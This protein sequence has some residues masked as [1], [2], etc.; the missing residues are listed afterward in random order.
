MRKLY[1]LLPFLF[2]SSVI[3]SQ[4]NAFEID[5]VKEK[6][7]TPY[8]LYRHQGEEG[9]AAFKKNQPFDYAKELWY[10]SE[11]FYVK[12]NHLSQGEVLNAA[13]IDI[14]RFENY[15]KDTEEAIVVV[16]GYKDVLVLLPNNKLLYKPN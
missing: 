3:L 9:L 12:R 14:S 6:M 2:L 11:S 7:F 4:N 1:I 15:R 5:P 8:M 13:M 10:Y 16:P